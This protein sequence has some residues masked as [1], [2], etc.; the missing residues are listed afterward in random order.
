[1][2]PQQSRFVP[3]VVLAI[4]TLGQSALGADWPE[5]RGPT[6]DGHAAASGDGTPSGLPLEWSESN[7]VRWKTEIPYRGWS[8][9]VVMD[10]QVWLTTATEDGHDFDAICVDAES[11]K[12]LHNERVFHCDEPEP[13]GNNVNCYAACSPAIEPGRVYV[14][15]GSYGTA[16]LDTS[17]GKVIW[18]RDDMPCR[19]Y[20]GPSSSVVL[21]ES[22]VILT[23]DGADLQYVTAVDKA[24]GETVWK[25]DRDVEWNDENLTGEYAKYADMAKE[26][27][28]RKAH[29]TPLIVEAG[30]QP[31]L[32][33]GGAKATFG[34]D[35]RT[36]RELWR[37]RYDDWSVAP[38]PLY[39][40][41]VAYIVTGLMHPELWAVKTSGTGDVTDSQ[42]LWRLKTGV[43]RTASPLLVD[44]LIYMVNDDGVAS[45][46]D[47]ESGKV[48]WKNRLGGRF[49]SSPIY[50]DGRIY[51]F[52][53]DG[54]TKVVK[55][56][57]KFELLATSRLDDGFM[58]SPAIAD[59]AFFLR[60]KSHLYRIEDKV[61]P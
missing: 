29:S 9:P 26:G 40:N 57:R 61:R 36:G 22:L 46:V 58:A 2:N 4:L 53:Q 18:K 56:G 23:F 19:H 21:F 30:G 51:F 60:T 12:L 32:V 47:A 27:D 37:V 52:N 20:R 11:G 34:Y 45:C 8:T 14:H 42:V 3:F 43:A 7:N 41:G 49:A 31:Q 1:M 10:G 17:T 48:V 15:F 33:S 59:G 54:E 35:P 55:P 13:L 24:S 25:T 16:C 50:A 6:G 38:R 28:F 39:Q 5:F 44:G